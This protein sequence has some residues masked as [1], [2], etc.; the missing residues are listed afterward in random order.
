M[1]VAFNITD[2]S[3]FNTKEYFDHGIVYY[4]GCAADVEDSLKAYIT[5]RGEIDAKSLMNDWFPSVDANVFISHAHG[6]QKQAVALAGWLNKEFGLKPFVDSCVWGDAN[7]LLKIIDKD[8]CSNEKPNSYDYEAR[9]YS[10]SHVHVMLMNALTKM[11]DRCETV[12]FLNS[13]KAIYKLDEIKTGTLSPWIFNE[14]ETTRTIRMRIPQRPKLKMF[15][16]E[17]LNEGIDDSLKVSYT[18]T[19]DHMIPLPQNGMTTWKKNGFRGEAAFDA[20][21]NIYP[22]TIKQLI[23]RYYGR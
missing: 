17:R 15:S 1:F 8:Y 13:E 2:F 21:Y 3:V 4:D 9:N 19:L 23:R 14:I 10:T 18:L 11:I 16:V 6:N 22:K 12:F 20:L 7:K 5:Q